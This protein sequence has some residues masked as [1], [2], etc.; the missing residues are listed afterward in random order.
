[1]TPASD[2]RPAEPDRCPFPRPFAPDFAECPTYQAATF[3]A[4]DSRNQP[5]GSWLTCRHLVTGTGTD[6]RGRYYPRCSLGTR[7]DRLRWL[8]AVGPAE[9]EVVRA[10]QAEFDA[11]STPYRQRLVELKAAELAAGHRRRMTIEMDGLLQEFLAA[12]EDFLSE[13]EPRF[14]EVGLPAATVLELVDEWS[15]AWAGS[16]RLAQAPSASQGLESLPMAAQALLSTASGGSKNGTGDTAANVDADSTVYEDGILRV[17]RTVD[18]PGLAVEGAVDATN[19]TA[20]GEALALAAAS[21]GD[22]LHVDLNGLLFCD[23]GGLRAL[24]GA[25]RPAPGAARLS[26]TGGSHH[27]GRAA[28]AAGWAGVLTA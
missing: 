7:R 27:L 14:G 12:V 17:W 8:A 26:I 1:M 23:L 24:V 16:D 6:Q 15:R 3:A 11:F 9:L 21:T 5:L 18:P 10:L 4:A 19:S 25:T 2:Q 22:E 20:F 28:E 13:R